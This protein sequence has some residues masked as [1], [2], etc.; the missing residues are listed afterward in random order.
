MPEKEPKNDTALSAPEAAPVQQELEM[1]ETAD[2]GETCFGDLRLQRA[3][4]LLVCGERSVRLSRREYDLM[5]LLMRNGSQ[6]VSKEQLI[7]KVW[8]DRKS[9]RL[10]SS[11]SGENSMPSSA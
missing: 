6:I 1:P 8:G 5:E 10:N 4:F 9:T 11:H 2:S 3:T 7:L